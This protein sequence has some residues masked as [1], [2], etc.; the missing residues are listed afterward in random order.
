MIEHLGKYYQEAPI[1]L[2]LM[3]DGRVLEILASADGTWTVLITKPNGMSCA[4]A[5][6]KAWSE[7]SRPA[8]SEST[9]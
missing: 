2:G 8:S 6:G 1:A 9:T 3:Q 5:W 7:Q 4:M